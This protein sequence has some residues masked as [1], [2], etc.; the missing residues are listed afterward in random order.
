M[1]EGRLIVF[2]W[3][4]LLL[5]WL[6]ANGQTFQNP[7]RP[8]GPDPFMVYYKGFYYL[9]YSS[10]NSIHPGGSAIEM[11]KAS[12]LAEIPSAQAVVVWQDESHPQRS[13][14]MWAP[15]LHR[16]LGTDG[17]HWYLYYTAGPT[18]CCESQR[19]HVLES[20]GDSPEGP[21]HYKDQ[22]TPEYAIDG[23]ILDVNGKLYLLYAQAREGNH[24]HIAPMSDPFTLSG[25]SVRISSA[26]YPWEK[27]AGSINEAPNA[28]VRNGRV[29]LTY[30]YNDCSSA[31]YGLGMLTAN[32]QADL[33]DPASWKKSATPVLQRSDRNHAYG[34]G[35]NGFFRSPD[36]KEDWIIYHANEAAS[37]GCGEKRSPRAQPFRWN[38]DGTP[39]FGIPVSVETPLALPSGDPLASPSASPFAASVVP[40]ELFSLYPNPV[41]GGGRL[42]VA[43]TPTESAA[44][45]V[46][47]HDLQG[48]LITNLYKGPV[49]AGTPLTWEF[50]METYPEGLYSV[51]IA[52]ST[53]PALR[54]MFANR[55][56]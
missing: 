52:Q 50:D 6:P 10:A 42:H 40:D 27:M 15:E 26:T 3:L 47:I 2:I 34:P 1:P 46:N 33:L 43:F 51:Q 20:D 12:S 18:M 31:S 38:G 28:L 16:L 22:L 13:A 9:T 30:S 35:H 24:I 48:R 19:V 21:Y 29:F 41:G 37:D 44:L 45:E 11:V 54:K 55:K 23:S 5:P 53:R 56:R 49:A 17:P 25:P 32:Q 4:C 8:G 39:D 14:N 36:G 7:L